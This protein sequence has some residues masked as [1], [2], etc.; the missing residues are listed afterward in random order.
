MQITRA[1]SRAQLLEWLKTGT[2]RPKVQARLFIILRLLDLGSATKVAK[3]L[4]YVPST[5][6]YWVHRFNEGGVE[7]LADSPRSGRPRKLTKKQAESLLD[8][9]PAAF[10]YPIELWTAK[11]LYAQLIKEGVDCSLRTVRRRVRELGYRPIKPR[12]RHYKADPKAR[13]AFKKSPGARN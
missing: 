13:A 1:V 11:V 10:G 7:A 2:N 3:D 9:S 4:H 12:V 6:C 8:K 5:V